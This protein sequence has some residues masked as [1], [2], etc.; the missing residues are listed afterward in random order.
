MRSPVLP[1]RAAIVTRCA[2]DLALASLMGGTAAIHDEP[3]RGAPPLYALFGEVDVRDLS[4]SSGD[5]HEQDFSIVV[6]AKPGSAATALAA[7]DRLAELLHDASL[8][9][10][11]QRL[12]SLAVTGLDARRDAETNLA[13]VALR[14][15]A[16]TE[17]TG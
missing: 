14:L 16:V 9:L 8:A 7:A 17:V 5:G 3:P 1:L 10:S 11:G 2:A 13:R 15:R 6:W 4:T 12:V